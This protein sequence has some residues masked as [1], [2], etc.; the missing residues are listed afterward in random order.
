MLMACRQLIGRAH[1]RSHVLLQVILLF[2]GWNSSALDK[3]DCHGNVLDDSAFIETMVR[4]HRD[5]AYGALSNRA[6]RPL[7]GGEGYGRFV[8]R[9]AT[10]VRN[11]DEL[12]AAVR[13]V[14]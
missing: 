10:V 1:S 3:T 13:V 4:D 2:V 11:A 8:A 5:T 7:G 9:P 6:E 14:T 12:R